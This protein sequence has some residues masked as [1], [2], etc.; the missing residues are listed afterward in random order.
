MAFT[1]R[2][3]VDRDFFAWHELFEGYCEFYETP[4]NDE[5]AVRAWSWFTSEPLLAEAMVA[6]D[7]ETGQLLGLAHF[8]E[9]V[10]ALAGGTGLYLDDLYVRP[11]ARGQG[12]GSALIER[13]R[14]IGVERHAFV[15]RWI[16]A[17]NNET[18]RRLYDRVAE[19][20]KWVTYDLKA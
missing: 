18:A 2:P 7:D 10:D 12:V 19:K 1:I 17:K 16:T 5:K 15:V 3:V 4:L 9:F 14:E 11:D 6:V 20:T 13:L 8:R